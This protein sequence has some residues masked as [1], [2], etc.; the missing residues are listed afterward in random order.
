[1]R[2]NKLIVWVIILLVTSLWGCGGS[3]KDVKTGSSS[4]QMLSDARPVDSIILELTGKDGRSV[5]EITIEKHQLDFIESAVGN[6]IKSIDSVEI[7]H[8]YGWMY[9]V[10]DTMGTVA[11]DKYITNDSDIVKW[12]YRKF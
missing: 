7:N 6:F 2:L 9:S 12:H 3:E 8:A 4:G 11:S 1:M 5:F 10:N